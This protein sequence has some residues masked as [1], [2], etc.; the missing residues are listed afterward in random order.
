FA[1]LAA[2]DSTHVGPCVDDEHFDS[3]Q[4]QAIQHTTNGLLVWD[5]ASN[6][7]KF[8]NGR[9]TL[10]LGRYG[11]EARANGERFYSEPD[12][13]GLPKVLDNSMEVTV[14]QNAPGAVVTDFSLAQ[15]VPLHIWLQGSGLLADE[16][17]SITWTYT[18]FY[19]IQYSDA[20]SATG[21][22]RVRKDLRACP[23]LPLPPVG[24][25]ADSSGGYVATLTEPGMIMGRSGLASISVFG[26]TSGANWAVR[27][28]HVA[29]EQG[30]HLPANCPRNDPVQMAVSEP[31]TPRR[32]SAADRC[33]TGQISLS[34]PQ[35]TGAAGTEFSWFWL[36][37]K[38][39]SA[40]WLYGYVGAQMYDNL[41][42]TLETRVIRSGDDLLP[43]PSAFVLLPNETAGF[44][45]S[46]AGNPREGHVCPSATSLQITPPDEWQSL[47]LRIVGPERLAPCGGELK[48]GAV[49]PA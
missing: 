37:N 13:E 3:D 46:W 12:T 7:A 18:P 24:V 30:D 16:P 2:V 33:H 45:V 22:V 47:T 19:W 6:L 9:E 5:K 10:V 20:T 11:L 28:A 49:Q 29:P 15:S 14:D 23:D 42:R 17:L 8:T 36:K 31:P 41:G 38:S 44:T 4:N 39:N 32:L 21:S 35:T 48:A 34:G 43:S 25:V 1:E 27:I 26:R 40:C